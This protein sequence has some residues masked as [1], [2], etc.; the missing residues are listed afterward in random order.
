MTRASIA[1]GGFI[2]AIVVGVA[3]GA[4]FYLLDDR[5]SLPAEAASPT[6]SARAAAVATTLIED[7]VAAQMLTVVF[8]AAVNGGVSEASFADLTANALD[9]CEKVSQNTGDR[10]GGNNAL[11][12]EAYA[13]LRKEIRGACYM[14]NLD[15]EAESEQ[16]RW[17]AIS[18]VYQTK[19]TTALENLPDY[20]PSQLRRAIADRE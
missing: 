10:S 1:I 7:K 15:V 17:G 12:P 4:T 6:P 14:L 19:I 11:I 8:I 20:S 9:E 16:L 13:A 5:D 2:A 18:F 3:A